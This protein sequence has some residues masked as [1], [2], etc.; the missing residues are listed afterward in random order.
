MTMKLLLVGL[1]LSTAQAVDHKN[2][3][4]FLRGVVGLVGSVEETIEKGFA[5]TLTGSKD[6]TTCD[7]TKSEDGTSCVWCSASS[8]GFC[9][10]EDIA[11]QMK[12]KIPGISCDDDSPSTDDAAPPAT[13]DDATPSDDSVPSD[14]WKCLTKYKISSECTAAG[15]AWCDNQGGYGIC[16]DKE[17]S[18][19]AS[20]SD[21]YTTCTTSSFKLGEEDKVEKVGLSDP[22]DSSCLI[23]SIS[24]DESTCKS[25]LDA[26]NTACEWCSFSE[27]TFC[28]N[29]D[30]A[31]IVEGY[32]ASCGKETIENF[33][34]K[35][36][37]SDPS[38]PSC[39]VVT[40]GGDESTCKST[41]DADNKPC[42]WCSLSDYT[43]CL[44]V[45]QAQIVEQYGVACNE[46]KNNS[47][48]NVDGDDNK[49]VADPND[50][51]CLVATMSGDES[52]CKSTMDADNK[53]C[54]WCSLAGY[55]F[56]LNT[57]Q[58]QI[59]EGY[60]ASCDTFINDS[61]TTSTY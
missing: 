54:E 20:K 51:S 19:N 34:D 26:D 43:F 37:L 41:M 18:E 7:G 42:E 2:D 53:S 6:Q 15:C 27:Y 60:G 36:E 30:Q 47:S 38:D 29:A 31:Q 4:G 48:D 10:S 25:T 56:C 23:A 28:L 22:S 17:A 58:A 21:W 61:I 52:A 39:L 35:Q 55:S 1:L 13:D 14:Y 50:P 5:C 32:G 8:V 57:D 24:G 16:M 12:G 9:V 46:E 45:D 3:I 49:D 11:V 33:A 44:N 40:M 59:V